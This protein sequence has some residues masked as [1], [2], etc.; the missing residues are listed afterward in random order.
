[1]TVLFSLRNFWYI[2]IFESVIRELSARGHAVRLVA[3]ERGPVEVEEEGEGADPWEAAAARLSAECAGVSFRYFER[4]EI[5]SW[6]A[7]SAQ[8][9]IAGDYL[10]FL[11][12]AYDGAP[13][14]KARA[15]ERAPEFVRGLGRV[16]PF[17]GAPGRQLLRRAFTMAEQAAPD[18]PEVTALLDEERPDVVL[19][20]P[21]V[22]LGSPQ[23]DILRVARH[24]GCRTALAVGSWDH[25]SSKALIRD[26]PDLVLV[27]NDTQ[28][29]EAVRFH[30]V[31][32]ARVA[33]TGAQCFDQWFGR[34]PALDARAFKS[35]VGLPVDRPYVLWVCSALFDGSPNEARFVREWVRA[36]QAHPVLREYGILIRPHPKR[37]HEWA[38]VR[39]DDLEGVAFWPRDA[40]APFDEGTKA[41]YFD[42][43]AHAAAVAGLNT[44]ALIEAGIAGRPVHTVLLPAF[45]DNQEGTLHFRYLLQ[46]GGG[47]LTAAT[48]LDEH[49]A[50]L[51]SSVT[52][53]GAAEAR[54]A[55]F[56]EA[57]VRPR[58]LDVPAAPRFVA[59]VEALAAAPAPAAQRPGVADRALRAILAPIA[60]R[61]RGT[62]SVERRRRF[63]IKRQQRA[64]EVHRREDDKRRRLEAE[65]DARRI[66]LARERA[67]DEARKAARVAERA[68]RLAEKERQKA[69]A[70]SRKARAKFVSR[71][72]ARVARLLGR[73]RSEEH[74]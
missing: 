13:M 10:R 57:F 59:A 16:W 2:K 68:G 24:R 60:R 32:E 65:E 64:E 4:D 31:P 62:E 52:D 53:P 66:R 1:M 17:N 63:E 26:V 12:S 51:A 41:D 40:A 49:V 29:D 61:T 55:R 70:I 15:G 21:L 69:A 9:R 30:H 19:V 33:V 20:S 23:F 27:W 42:S 25:L 5:G 48:A 73:G 3:D 37:L 47:L 18:P 74:T 6:T 39:V 44:S 38:D 8:T 36:V 45:R 71:M 35:R 11:D 67:D 72:R 56:L 50:Q 43:M 22:S 54:T 58:G 46:V 34:A 14:L 28:R 7:F